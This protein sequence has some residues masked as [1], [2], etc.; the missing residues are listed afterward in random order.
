[1]LDHRRCG[2]NST[3]DMD[4]M[5]LPEAVSGAS[6]LG[7]STVA[8]RVSASR[9]GRCLMVYSAL[10]GFWVL[11]F[12]VGC[13]SSPRIAERAEGPPPPAVID[14][15]EWTYVARAGD[16]SWYLNVTTL[17]RATDGYDFGIW[18][19]SV[20]DE[21]HDLAVDDPALRALGVRYYDV[22]MIDRLEEFR[23]RD[24]A[25]I[26]RSSVFRYSDGTIMPRLGEPPLRQATYAV[27]GTM[28]EDLV[29]I[30]CGFG[31]S[32]FP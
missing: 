26:V 23:C 15:T 11:L 29:R 14:T 5:I 2:A 1:M 7:N 25:S 6:T 17:Y 28:G 10:L 30:V 32:L 3:A 13:R 12:A 21:P 22:R 24:L 16:S 31:R 9:G 4:E 18:I 20:S 8:R 19:R 27:P